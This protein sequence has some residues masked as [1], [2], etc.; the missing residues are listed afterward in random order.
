M[1]GKWYFLPHD[2]DFAFMS[3]VNINTLE[4]NLNPAETQ[5]SPLFTALMKRAD[6]R[7]TYVTYMLDMINGAFSPENS[8]RVVQDVMTR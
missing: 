1:D 5:Y 7:W 4:R 6:C 8:E 3:D 2:T